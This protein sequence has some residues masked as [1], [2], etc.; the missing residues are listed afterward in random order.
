MEV[1]IVGG[2]GIVSKD[3]P[4]RLSLPSDTYIS[5]LGI[6][7][8]IYSSEGNLCILCMIRDYGVFIEY[9]YVADKINMKLR[10]GHD[11]ETSISLVLDEI[12]K[13]GSVLYGCTCADFK[14]RYQYLATSRNDLTHMLNPTLDP[15]LQ[16][17]PKNKGLLCKHLSY[18]FKNVHK[19]INDNRDDI[20][21]EISLYHTN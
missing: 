17:N 18:L 3:T 6:D 1:G 13:R 8:R 10:K 11:L 20:I 4:S 14:Y 5:Y 16:T 15:A 2:L 12:I 7:N 21:Y 9:R 19:L